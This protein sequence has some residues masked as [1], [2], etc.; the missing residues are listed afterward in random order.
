MSVL[1]G[2]HC[3]YCEWF[4]VDADEPSGRGFSCNYKK[5][6]IESQCMAMIA[7]EE[8]MWKEENREWQRKEE[9]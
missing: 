4:G 1:M 6:D 7:L 9:L 2:T 8:E 3:D 5:K